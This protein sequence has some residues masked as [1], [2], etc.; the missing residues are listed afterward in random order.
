V[1]GNDKHSFLNAAYSYYVVPGKYSLAKLY[2]SAL[3]L[4]KKLGIDVFNALNLLEN[5]HVLKDLK[6]GIG[7]G[8]LHYYLYNWHCPPIAPNEVGIVLL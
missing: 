3:V 8:Q 4:A 7:D 2:E 1:I 6:F 5:G